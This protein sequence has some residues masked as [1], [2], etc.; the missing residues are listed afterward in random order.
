MT[1]SSKF[2]VL[3]I[4]PLPRPSLLPDPLEYDVIDGLRPALPGAR[5]R[6]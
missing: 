1:P 5:A 3:I 6:G 2:G 4:D